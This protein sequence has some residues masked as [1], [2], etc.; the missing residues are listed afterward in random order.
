MAKIKGTNGDD[1]LVGTSGDDIINSLLGIDSVDGGAG[2]DVLTI[3]YGAVVGSVF[4]GSVTVN[5]DGTL[6]GGLSSGMFG[7]PNATGF[8][9]VERL[10]YTGSQDVD[11]ITVDLGT[12]AFSAKRLAMDGG[13]GDDVLVLN[14]AQNAS[15]LS[16]IAAENGLIGSN[17]GSFANWEAFDISLGAAKPNTVTTGS[18]D[19]RVTTRGLRD[20]IDLG[21]G[22][23]TW[24]GA[25]GTWTDA[26]T[27]NY[28]DA[29]GARGTIGNKAFVTVKN[30]EV[31]SFEFGNG[32]NV[33][34]LVDGAGFVFGYNS[35]NDTLNYRTTARAIDATLAPHQFGGLTGTISEQVNPTPLG[36]GGFEHGTIRGG[37]GANSFTFDGSERR[38][39]AYHT[40]WTFVGG[41]SGGDT[42]TLDL[43]AQIESIVGVDADGRRTLTENDTSGTY[44]HWSGIETLVVRFG[45][46]PNVIAA[47]VAQSV[48]VFGGADLDTVDF[49][50]GTAALTLDLGSTAAQ[51]TAD[52][53]YTL[54]GVEGVIGTAYGDILIDSAAGNI[55]WGSLGDDRIF[56]SA[57]STGGEDWF[58]GGLGTDL[59]SYGQAASGVTVS[60]ALTTLQTTGGGGADLLSGFENLFGSKFADTL[61][62]DAGA[63]QIGGFDGDDRIEGLGGDD[64]LDGG[65]GVNT[66]SYAQAGA[67]VTV[68]LA[69]GTATGGA[70]TDTLANFVNVVGSGY[71]DTLTGTTGANVFTGGRG[72][73]TLT[74]GAGAD[75]FVLT[76]KLDSTGAGYDRI[77]DWSRSEGDRIDAVE[78]SGRL[79]DAFHWIGSDAFGGTAGEL[80]EVAARGGG[81]FL[82]GDTDGDRTADVTIFVAGS[83]PV[84]PGDIVL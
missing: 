32:A 39:D 76:S 20:T 10:V 36:L 37:T 61:T 8:E 25:Y 38:V 27:L 50:T 46:G 74:G 78:A 71:A 57:T 23:D 79:N 33:A 13:A 49:Q 60:L 4:P 21:A 22:I 24:T 42:L 59:I 66:V 51:A 82:Y 54:S 80:R 9:N 48:T 44:L 1:T 68:S 12:L 29:N 19:D 16:L 31:L 35:D 84:L 2:Y 58:D 3:D 77:T 64:A 63:N 75:T 17:A 15:G 72:G 69:A 65:A 70:G 11:Y 45:A 14:A 55:I 81:W 6:S 26:M 30:L 40:G 41:R 18:G 28:S 43:Q 52:G 83:T 73:D 56:S 5:D 7:A 53:T 62:G 34:T 67:A 47:G